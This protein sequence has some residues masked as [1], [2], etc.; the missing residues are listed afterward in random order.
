MSMSQ[1][2]TSCCATVGLSLAAALVSTQVHAAD[3]TL[4]EIIVTATR[5]EAALI[6]VPYSAY[7]VDSHRIFDAG[8][9]TLQQALSD[10]PGIMVQETSPGQGS[11]F[12]RGFTGYRTLMLIDGV[13]LN[14]SVFRDGPNQYWGTVD[15]M[16]V[17]R[18]EI[19]SGAAGALY[20]TDAVG[21][22]VNVVSRRLDESRYAGTYRVASAEHSHIANLA[23]T[24]RF[25]DELA[26][27]LG[28]T[29]KV[30]GDLEGGGDVGRQ[31][32]IGY[33]EYGVDLK[34]VKDFGGEHRFQ[35]LLQHLEQDDVPRTHA[36]RVAESWEGTSVGS[37]YKRNLDQ[38]R[39]L[40]YAKYI[41]TSNVLFWDRLEAT[42]SWHAMFETEDRLDSRRR[43]RQQ[44]FNVDTLGFALQLNKMTGYGDLA[45]GVEIYNDS[46]GSF[47]SSNAI[48]G[49]V[50]DDATYRTIDVFV[51]DIVDVTDRL[52]LIGGLRYARQEVDAESVQDPI[53]G[54]RVSISQDWD[55][56]AANGR[57]RYE[58]ADGLQL[59]GGV[60]QGFRAPNLSDLSRLDIALSGELEVAAPD[61][62]PE[63]FLS[64]ELG[65]KYANERLYAQASFFYTAIE[66]MIV[67]A[68]TGRVVN[69]LFE[70]TKRNAGDGFVRG[71]ELSGSYRA[72]E[73][74]E[75]FGLFAWQDGE[76]EGYPTSAPVPVTEP[77]SRLLPT[78]FQLGTRWTRPDQRLWAELA[79]THAWRQDDLSASDR[80][81]TQRIPPG[82]TPSFTVA[83]AAV[84][85]RINDYMQLAFRV[86]NF[87]DEDYRVHGSGTNMPGRNFILEMSVSSR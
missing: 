48:Q 2:A 17:D 76:V 31:N 67:R 55:T 39:Q 84:G 41:N 78:Q 73:Q 22:V 38:D 15:H 51:Q 62:S 7:L 46:V 27:G 6:E 70:V 25:N 33:D 34:I 83:D 30:F 72:H 1:Y 52:T 56:I 40:A 35:F 21:G 45:Y 87:T 3:S 28:L 69:H 59:F 32:G 68:P 5:E 19:V 86:D 18:L 9:R 85:W 12:I 71:V 54:G 63:K 79:V 4:E 8:Y 26:M 57:F 42:L 29:G 50:A 36:T 11:P 13:K 49:P 61:L 60:S 64:F 65:S 14:N 43:V 23:F 82:G 16:G 24:Q 75:L 10:V 66:D 47:S 81:D 53:T 20:G 37:D 44:S 80:R 77:V 74:V 58:I